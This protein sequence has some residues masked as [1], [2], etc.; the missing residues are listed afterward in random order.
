MNLQTSSIGNFLIV[1]G[2]A[3]ACLY[4]PSGLLHIFIGSG[5]YGRDL[6]LAMHM[7]LLTMY[8]ISIGQVRSLMKYAWPIV[9]FV[10]FFWP[11]FQSRTQLK[12][13]LITLKW[14]AM[15]ID[16]MGIGYLIALKPRMPKLA[17]AFC[18][19]CFL[20][21]LTDAAIGFREI[22]TNHLVL[23]AESNEDT[24]AGVTAA[25]NQT[26][27]GSIRVQGLQRDVF[28]FGNL[29]GVGFATCLAMFLLRRGFFLRLTCIILTGFFGY[30]GFNS[31]GRSV[32]FGMLLTGLFFVIAFFSARFFKQQSPK[33]M[34]IALVAEGIVGL[35][36]IGQTLLTIVN[37]MGLHLTVLNLASSFER[38]AVWRERLATMADSPISFFIGMPSAYYIGIS[39]DPINFVDNLPL[40]I[41]YHT[42]IV[43]VVFFTIFFATM[44]R[45]RM[46][47]LHPEG[48][49]V[50]VF[51]MAMVWGEGLARDTLGMYS[52]LPMFAAA[53]FLIGKDY[54]DCRAKAL[55]TNATE[56]EPALKE[57]P[58]TLIEA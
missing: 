12:D 44:C 32:L 3:I 57:Q 2:A 19:C 25:R 10:L 45:K 14:Y 43:G 7:L 13:L 30:V 36:G 46:A 4:E 17:T 58:P 24:A 49:L 56:T 18:I 48:Y 15:W 52:C 1:S 35:I 5:V 31:G 40:W 21:I 6:L 23:P 51:F 37:G 50:F 42:G 20:L 55:T 39:G 8:F 26:L 38:D 41:F 16:W 22:T 9:F 53:G 29:M 34:L 28:S 27:E 47:Y 33:I 11:L 54:L